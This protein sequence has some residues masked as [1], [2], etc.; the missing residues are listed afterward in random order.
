MGLRER[1]KQQTRLTLL[2][3][4]KTLFSEMEYEEV[5]IDEI[6]D[7]AMISQKTFFNYFSSKA[8]LLEELLLNWLE[9]MNIWAYE[10]DLELSL[11][12]AIVPPN[13]DQIQ[14]WIINHRHILKMIMQHTDLL[15][16][17]YSAEDGKQDKNTLFP[18]EYRKPRLERVKKAQEQGIIRAD[19]TPDLV[20]DLYDYLRIDIVQFWLSLPDE[21]ATPAEYKKR[22]N[23]MLD[24]L[25]RGLAP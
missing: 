11:K 2:E 12:S 6:A 24:V 3:I 7:R 18:V 10:T 9:E 23:Q 25:L 15:D 17:I 20:C 16:S 1:K 8:V 14:E 19:L 13:L 5:K 4:A 22:Y 21:K